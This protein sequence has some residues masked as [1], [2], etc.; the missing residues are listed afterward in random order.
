M[1][2]RRY[3][4]YASLL[5][6]L[7]SHK[8]CTNPLLRFYYWKPVLF[9]ACAGTETWYM[10][11]YAQAHMAPGGSS[12]ATVVSALLYVCTPICAFKQVANFVQM[13]VACE[14]LVAHDAKK[15]SAA[16]A[17]AEATRSKSPRK[18]AS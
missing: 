1:R 17:P 6:G 16:A 7:G 11:L 10:A 13:Y 4:M 9:I 2:A 12:I 3:H 5:L 14:A 18:R 8:E 15:K